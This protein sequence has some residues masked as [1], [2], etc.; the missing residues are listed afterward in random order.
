MKLQITHNG[1][2]AEEGMK[3]DYGAK[4]GKNYLNCMRKKKQPY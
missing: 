3:N 2:I 1:R 4:V